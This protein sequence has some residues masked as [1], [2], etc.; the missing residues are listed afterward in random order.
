MNKNWH[1]CLLFVG[2][3]V[4]IRFPT[5]FLSVIDHD[6]STY[7]VIADEWLN[8]KTLYKDLID[9]KP[10]GIFL[11]FAAY[12]KLFGESI[13]GLRVFG[14]VIIGLTAFMLFLVL[15]KFELRNRSACFAGLA[16]LLMTTFH[17]SLAVNTEIFMNFF[18]VLAFLLVFQFRNTVGWFGF[19][20][21]F[22]LSFCVKYLALFDY[23]FLGAFCL[24]SFTDRNE[25]FSAKNITRLAL[26]GLG[27]VLPFFLTNLYFY[28]TENFEEFAFITY[29]APGNYVAEVQWTDRLLYFL[30][31]N[32]TFIFFA[33]PFYF[34]IFSNQTKR[35][36]KILAALWFAS[37][38]INTQITGQFFSHYYLHF[39]P[40]LALGC[41]LFFE[42]KN[43]RL[44]NSVRVRKPA[45]AGFYTISA[46]ASLM[47]LLNYFEYY[48]REDFAR[49]IADEVRP[50]L[51]PDDEIFPANNLQIL[52]FLLNKTPVTPY[53]HSTILTKK[54]HVNTLEINLPKEYE[55]IKKRSPKFILVEKHHPV[56]SFEK[57][58]QANYYLAK[59]FGK[60]YFLYKRREISK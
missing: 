17:F 1:W 9:L 6:E 48:K 42:L 41:G 7:L 22:G 15:K 28:A 55:K 4:I 14:S 43:R 50:Q 56:R 60:K 58:I 20:L 49:E 32:V 45:L 30:N 16:Y 38:L 25:L 18:H 31:M 29:E 34:G 39:S 35:P 54:V 21:L 13:F 26:T 59:K 12:I 52:Y 47:F 44:F 3:A 10:P 57:F 46:I 33:V 51:N 37:A 8:G 24:Y 40:G 53:V 5:F 23:V 2:L 19:G 36:V 11:I 27:F